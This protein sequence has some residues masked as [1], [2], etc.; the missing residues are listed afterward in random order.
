MDLSG[1][2]ATISGGPSGRF[3]L[4]FER[5]NDL[6]ATTLT[7]LYLLLL[8]LAVSALQYVFAWLQV[9]WRLLRAPKHRHTGDNFTN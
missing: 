5:A 1:A 2:S 7:I 9:Q 4:S 6:E 3:P 8:F